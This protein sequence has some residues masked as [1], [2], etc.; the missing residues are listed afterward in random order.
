MGTIN[1]V[2]LL[3]DASSRLLVR[4][5]SEGFYYLAEL[6]EADY[7]WH[8]LTARIACA[9]L[10]E[11]GD[12]SGTW[13]TL[14]ELITHDKT[15]QLTGTLAAIDDQ[16]HR[17]PYLGMGENEYIYRFRTAKERNRAIYVDGQSEALYQSVLCQAIKEA[18][19]TREKSSGEPALLDFGAVSYVIPSHFGFCLG[20]QNAI[21]RAY[22]TVALNPDRRVFMLSEL[23]HNPFVNE[24][25]LARGLRYLQSDKGMPLRADGT[26]ANSKNDPTALWNQ[27]T[28]N[29]IVII[30]AFGATNE[31]KARLIRRGIVIRANDATCMLVEKVWKAARRYAKEGYTVLIHGKSEHEETKATFSNASTYGPALMLRNME[32]ARRLAEVIQAAAADK[33]ALFETSFAGLYSDGFDQERDLEKIAV[34]NQTTLLRNETLNII[35]YL[36]DVIAAK[37]GEA[38][39]ADHLWSK[40]KGDT[41]CY[42]TQ[43]NQDALHKAVDMSIDAALVVGGKNSSNT[44]QLYRVCAERFGESAHY[45]QSE[46]NI[47]SIDTVRHYIF[48][49]NLTSA[50][51]TVEE[52]R[53]LLQKPVEKPR[54]LL[55]GGASCPDGII[56][57]VIHRINSFFPPDSIRPVE[58]VLQDFR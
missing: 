18:R 23:I 37:F 42:A 56:Q 5:N 11:R 39:V 19:R 36:R 53:P 43:V 3:F 12:A 58:E 8:R 30:P 51:A 26:M 44:F 38:K 40:G 9:V 1:P 27:L 48:P 50:P 10:P 33:A 22:E 14:H 54:I 47:L 35:D 49:Y 55:T 25:L 4:R 15:P 21:E 31:D 34:V 13:L 57:Q 41:L 7:E 46:A 2:R 32:H 17:I 29:D 6:Y 52:E 28:Q 24:D 45:I 16:L 20:V